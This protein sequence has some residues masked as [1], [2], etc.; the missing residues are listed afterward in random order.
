[1]QSNLCY[2]C[3]R[4]LS[5]PLRIFV[6]EGTVLQTEGQAQTD[7][8]PIIWTGRHELHFLVRCEQNLTLMAS[9][10]FLSQSTRKERPCLSVGLFVCPSVCPVRMFQLEKRWKNF[11]ETL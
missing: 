7:G 5:K 8:W 4:P 1:M 6:P 2:D 10:V 9:Y 3:N 11:D